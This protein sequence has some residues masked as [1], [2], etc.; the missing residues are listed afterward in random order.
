ML[1]NEFNEKPEINLVAALRPCIDVERW[2]QEIIDARPYAA[3]EEIF[4]TAKSAAAPFTAQEVTSALAHH[5]RIGERAGGNSAE[6][7]LSRSEQS[8]VDP[9]DA[10][11]VSALAEGNRAYEAKFDQVFLIRAAGRSPN[12]IIEILHR[13]LENTA[14]EEA[15]IVAQQ[16]REIALLR[17]EGVMSA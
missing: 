2:I 7:S 4:E 9:T 5:P 3:V 13:R 15:L 11:I 16:L 8:A 1:L 17:L 6:A 10:A 14:E 12:E